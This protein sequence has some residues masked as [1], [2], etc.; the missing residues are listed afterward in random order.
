MP[1][2]VPSSS[3]FAWS[4]DNWGANPSATPGTA[5]TPGTSSAEGSW[6][7]IASSA[8]IAQDVYGFYLSFHT[9]GSAGGNRP[10]MVD[11]GV[12]PA[13]GTSYSAIISNLQAGMAGP[14]T[15]AGLR[16][17][18]FP[19][20][21]KAGS[22]VAVRGSVD[23]ADATTFRCAAEFYG[24]PSAPWELPV[25]TFCR[26][27][28][29]DGTFP[30]RGLA[31]TPGNAA[32]GSWVDFGATS[33]PLW[34]WQVGHNVANGAVTAQYTYFELAFGD[35]SNKVTILKNMHVGTTSE[36]VGLAIN[37][38]LL[39]HECY[40][41][42]PSGANLYVRARCNTTPNTGYNFTVHG[43]GG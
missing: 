5:V 22:S 10:L 41:P 6:T 25:G 28:G 2:Y 24:Q 40:H 39:W 8:N 29:Q 4:Y 42:V 14:L 30:G 18:F 13:G 23:P 27:F 15:A 38:N 11:I 16:E 1:L 33:E 26:S 12:D 36:L 7:Q 34:W 21:I 37:S 17:H 32:D 20:F 43:V 3:G 19:L 35:G 31:V 9:H